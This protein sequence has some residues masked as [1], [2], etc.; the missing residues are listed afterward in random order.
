M[1]NL[2]KSACITGLIWLGATSS[3]VQA[4]LV[5][6]E[7]TGTVNTA[8]AIG[9]GNNAS[10]LFGLEAGDTIT[11]TGWFDDSV[12]TTDFFG[13]T[14]YS[15]IGPANEMTINVGTAT[16]TDLDDFIGGGDLVLYGGSFVGLDYSALTGDFDSLN[17]TFLS[18]G[19][20]EG[21]WNSITLTAVPVPAA[22]WLMGSGLLA[23]VGF[24]R[25]KQS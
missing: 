2:F 3:S 20:F 15:F 21:V 13:N 11:A 8:T 25:K 10:F 4:S 6:F 5:N 16:F 18:T 14:V 7:L 22:L 1:N 9:N 17:N 24:A 12:F 19:A 23:L